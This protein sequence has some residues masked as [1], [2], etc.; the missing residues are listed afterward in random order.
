VKSCIH[1]EGFDYCFQS[2]SNFHEVKDEEFH[3]L[4]LAYLNA[5]KAL[6]EYVNNNAEEE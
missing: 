5:A 4:R 2:Y 1:N 6:E 3:K